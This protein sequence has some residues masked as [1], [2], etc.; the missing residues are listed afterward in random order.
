MILIDCGYPKCLCLIEDI[1]ISNGVDIKK[2]SKIIITHHDFDHMGSLA[3]FKRKYPNIE[4]LSSKE[5]EIYVS[6]KKIIKITTSR[7][8]I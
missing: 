7:K 3:E 2:L 8:Y 5:D 4:I 6:G 1:A